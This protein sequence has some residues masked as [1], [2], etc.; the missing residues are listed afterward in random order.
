MTFECTRL[1][2]EIVSIE[3]KQVEQ[4]TV[5]CRKDDDNNFKCLAGKSSLN[6]T[7]PGN[8]IRT[9]AFFHARRC[10][11]KKYYERQYP[12]SRDTF[13][14]NRSSVNLH[15][16]PSRAVKDIQADA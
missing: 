6:A 2:V 7:T 11:I 16:Q 4:L 3:C 10:T 9:V 5:C 12:C 1:K 15:Y 13:R 14:V 8:S